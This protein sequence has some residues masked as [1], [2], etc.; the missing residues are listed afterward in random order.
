MMFHEYY[1]IYCECFSQ[2]KIT[3][4][5]YIKKLNPEKSHII[6]KEIHG[7][8]L[9]YSIIHGN[10]IVLLC[11]KQ[12]HRN[13]GYGSQLLFEAEKYI[14][15][16]GSKSVLLGR[17]SHYLFQGVPFDSTQ[18]VAFFKNRGYTAA[19]ISANM[20]FNL[21]VFDF[22][23]RR[24]PL[25]PPQFEF[26][27][28]VES[29]KLSLLNAVMETEPTW[30]YYFEACSDPILVATDH[31]KIIGFIIISLDDALKKFEEK[32]VGSIGCIGVIP[33]YR[34]R[35]VGRQLVVHGLK[36]LK[37]QACLFVEARYVWDIQ[38]YEKLGFFNTGHQWMG[39]KILKEL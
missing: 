27:F 28:A 2:Y 34:K 1:D 39:E 30:R 31:N 38:W 19:W 16:Q 14:Y 36:W 21:N 5:M 22:N 32:K 4:D 11:V 24:I 25:A 12:S 35:G 13:R 15:N 8:V 23:M 20:A 37:R 6:F 29:D 10:S 33:E 3:Y 18:V 9:G 17:G 7:D 26:R